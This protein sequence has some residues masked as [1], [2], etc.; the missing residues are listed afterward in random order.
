MKINVGVSKR[1]VHLTKES[2]K[3]LF[4]TEVL[5]ERNPLNQ[6]GQFASTETV[7]L[8]WNDKIIPHVRIIGPFRNYNQIELD[9]EDARFLNINPPRRQSGDLDDSLPITL[10]GPKKEVTLEKGAILAERHIHMDEINAKKYNLYNNEIV[11]VYKDNNYKFD[12]KIKISK[13]AYIE[14][15]IDTCEE[16][17]Y[18]LHQKDEVII[19]VENR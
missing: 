11:S 3:E 10:I 18:D 15:H 5:K 13:E 2:Y 6:P 16:K 1:H 12:A 17:E 9:Y 14:L 19:N 8:K 4:E 7:D